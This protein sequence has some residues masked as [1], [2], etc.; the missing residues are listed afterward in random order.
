MKEFEKFSA[1]EY[2]VDAENT[3]NDNKQNIH[4]N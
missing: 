1:L 2:F 4:Q 3:N